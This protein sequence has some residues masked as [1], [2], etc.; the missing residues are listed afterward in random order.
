MP[1]KVNFIVSL[2]SYK[3]QYSSAP[4]NYKTKMNFQKTAS[5]V[6]IVLLGARH[7]WYG[8]HGFAYCDW[9]NVDFR[10]DQKI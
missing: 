9:K 7:V 2:T 4:F 8:F 1:R 3:I 10:S 5:F 6:F